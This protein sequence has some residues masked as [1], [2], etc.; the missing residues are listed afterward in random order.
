[1]QQMQAIPNKETVVMNLLQQYPQLGFLVNALRGGNSL[2]SIASQMANLKGYNI[3]EI[4]QQ[5]SGG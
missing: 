5:L 1:M 4:I 2:E 3:N